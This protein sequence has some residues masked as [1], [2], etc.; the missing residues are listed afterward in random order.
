MIVFGVW[1]A[2]VLNLVFG[3]EELVSRVLRVGEEKSIRVWG[4]LSNFTDSTGTNHS[5][6]T[7][8]GIPFAISPIKHLRFQVF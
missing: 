2:S 3:Q 4:R 5:H 7:F 6:V 8:L 1:W